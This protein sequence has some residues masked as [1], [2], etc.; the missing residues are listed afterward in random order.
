M[1]S[2]GSQGGVRVLGDGRG[3]MGQRM[4]G[5][6][7]GDPRGSRDS[8]VSACACSLNSLH[9]TARQAQTTSLAVHLWFGHC[10][11]TNALLQKCAVDAFGLVLQG[12]QGQRLGNYGPSK[13]AG[14]PGDLVANHESSPLGPSRSSGP[15]KIPYAQGENKIAHGQIAPTIE[16]A[17]GGLRSGNLPAAASSLGPGK[18]LPSTTTQ[19]QL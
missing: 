2:L 5:S 19:V 10:L 8:Q 13:P 14:D 7:L 4:Q 3:S 11:H 12:S 15:I 6:G 18:R 17:A 16:D 1:D 9:S